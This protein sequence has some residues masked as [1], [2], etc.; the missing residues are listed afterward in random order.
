MERFK[1]WEVGDTFPG[2]EVLEELKGLNDKSEYR[3]N[4]SHT[5]VIQ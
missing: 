5:M 2:P 3:E 1:N 4:D